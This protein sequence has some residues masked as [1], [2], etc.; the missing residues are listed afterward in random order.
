MEPV[1]PDSGCNICC[2]DLKGEKFSPHMKIHEKRFN[3]DD[4]VLCPSC[5]EHISKRQLNPHFVQVRKCI[6]VQSYGDNIYDKDLIAKM[7]RNDSFFILGSRQRGWLLHR[8]FAGY[9][10]RPNSITLVKG[11]NS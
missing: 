7:I 10:K 6:R 4:S 11:K 9:A 5:N 1:L 3:L 8:M 2:D